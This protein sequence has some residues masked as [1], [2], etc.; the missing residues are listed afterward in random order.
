[1]LEA[2]E[3]ALARGTSTVFV[4]GIMVSAAAAER[5]RDLVAEAAQFSR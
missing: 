2:R 3:E 4:N 1:V 5:A